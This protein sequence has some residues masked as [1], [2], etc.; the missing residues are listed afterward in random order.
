MIRLYWQ[1]HRAGQRLVLLTEQGE[2]LET[3]LVRRTPRGYD[4]LAK[5][6]GYD[7]GRARKDFA[8]IEE[9]KAF[10][11]SF[12]PWELYYR[13]GDLRVEK[14]IR[15]LPQPPSAP[16]PGVATAPVQ[17]EKAAQPVPDKERSR[18]QWWQFWM[19]G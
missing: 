11:E 3:G 1:E 17:E 6:A 4:A 16:N 5:S 9:A 10:V 13:E 19:K 8:T 18:R 7:P 15:P 2:E 14:E 12:H